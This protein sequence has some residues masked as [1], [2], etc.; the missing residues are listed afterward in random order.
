[1][2]KCLWKAF[3]KCPPPGT[4]W[5][6]FSH[7]FIFFYCLWLLRLACYHLIYRNGLWFH[8]FLPPKQRGFTK[9]KHL[10]EKIGKREG[11]IEHSRLKV[12][13]LFI[14][15]FIRVFFFFLASVNYLLSNAFKDLEEGLGYWGWLHRFQSWQEHQRR[16]AA[17]WQTELH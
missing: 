12:I 2:M 7:S 11:L 14:R 16:W 5:I 1:M 9:P 3:I 8:Q 4:V 13:T 15:L 10:G 6:N 17:H